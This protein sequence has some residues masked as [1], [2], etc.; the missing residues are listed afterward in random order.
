VISHVS[1]NDFILLL[2]CSNPSR[3]PTITAVRWRDP[4][5]A[6]LRSALVLSHLPTGYDNGSEPRLKKRS[7]TY[8]M[9]H[10]QFQI[11]RGWWWCEFGAHVPAGAALLELSRGPPARRHPAP[12][13]SSYS[14]IFCSGARHLGL[15]SS[16]LISS[17]AIWAAHPQGREAITRSQ[18]EAS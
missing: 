18:G 4:H 10:L 13:F 14:Y 16:S 12:I 9:A 7:W 2:I 1:S 11:Y 8:T 6:M 15:S 17:P 3:P 5:P